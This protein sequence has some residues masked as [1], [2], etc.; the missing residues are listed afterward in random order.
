[1]INTQSK[2]YIAGHKGFVGNAV[3]RDLK[4]KNY[5]YLITKTRKELDLLDQ[6]T[7][8]DFLKTEKPDCVIL[9][10]AKVGGILPNSTKPA[11]FLCNYHYHLPILPRIHG[12]PSHHSMD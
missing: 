12:D 11:E 8:L 3:L 10:A 5:Q 1:M 2:I 7:T 9:C 6:N 4:Q